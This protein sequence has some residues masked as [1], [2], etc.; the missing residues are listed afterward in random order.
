MDQK[1]KKELYEKYYQEKQIQYMEFWK[2]LEYKRKNENNIE[3]TDFEKEDY[4]TLQNKF[5]YVK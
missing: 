1:N 4:Q 2:L 3:L 5:K